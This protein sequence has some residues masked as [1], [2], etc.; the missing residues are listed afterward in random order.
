MEQG[1]ASLHGYATKFIKLNCFRNV[2]AVSV[3]IIPVLF[4][5]GCSRDKKDP[6]ERITAYCVRECVLET[7]DS[8]TC[9]TKCKCA[10]K[11]LADGL[12]VKEFADLVNEILQ[13]GPNADQYRHRFRI[14]FVSCPG[15]K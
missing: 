3:C 7:S 4:F 14:A 1:V 5:C 9:D 13:K 15:I 8:E 11:K 6:G 12:S 10:A 2:V